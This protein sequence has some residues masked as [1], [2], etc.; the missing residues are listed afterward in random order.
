MEKPKVS[1]IIPTYNSGATLEKCLRSLENQTYPSYEIIVIDSFSNDGTLRIAEKFRAKT[2]QQ[3]SNPAL[4]RNIGVTNSTGKYVLFLDSD[5][6]LS[7]SVVAECITKCEDERAGMVIIPET[8]IGSGFWGSCSAVWK[9]CYQKVEQLYEASGHMHSGEPRFFVKE[10]IIRVG[11]L[12]AALIWGEDYDLHKRLRKAKV[13]EAMCE[14]NVYHY[15]LESLNGIL[16]KNFHYG[17]SVPIFE[18]QTGERMFSKM[19]WQALL[20]FRRIL[21]NFK[22]SPAIILGCMILLC[23]K[24]CSMAVGSMIGWQPAIDR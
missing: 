4:A 16:V 14:S 17:K 3:R 6:V 7:P 2:I 20:T 5:Q 19:L 23:L 15:E 13:K 12:D 9:N 1:I 10:Q 21:R 24:T 11:M 18:Q 8:F 22:S